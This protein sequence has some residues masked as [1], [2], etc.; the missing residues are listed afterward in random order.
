MIAGSGSPSR[1]GIHA[2]FH[3]LHYAFF[4]KLLIYNIF[5]MIADSWRPAKE[6]LWNQRAMTK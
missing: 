6:L 1:D 5:I 4:T 3:N 2:K